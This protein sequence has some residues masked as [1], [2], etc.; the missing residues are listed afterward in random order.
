MQVAITFDDGY[1]SLREQ[2]LPILK[3]AGAVATVFLNT[4]QIAAGGLRNISNAALGYYPDELFLSQRDVVELAAEGWS[5]G[6][7]GVDHIDLTRTGEDEAREELGASKRA[8]EKLLSAECML[9]AYTWGRH[10]RRL[11]DL[12]AEAG[13]RHAF[14]G[15]HG[16]L[17]ADSDRWALP[18]INVASEYAMSD[19]KAIVLGD[20]DYLGWI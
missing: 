8:I 4:G 6:S 5:I 10:D 18:R 17:R 1:A 12:V 16:P 15:W 11:R 7:H 3:A 20:W 14:S 19:F 9:F 13:Y 2:A